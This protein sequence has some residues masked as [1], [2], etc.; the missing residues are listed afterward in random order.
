[1][2]DSNA[3]L[4]QALR[5][6][7]T[8]RPPV[9]MMRQ[10]GRYLPEYMELRR[11]NDFLTRCYNPEIAAEITLQ[12]LRRFSFD[13]GIIFSDIL[14][15]LHKMG[16]DL[17]FRP[18]KGPQIDNPVRNR[19]DV[20]KL[21]E[22]VTTRDLPAVLEAIQI[23]NEKANVPILG[24]AGAPFTMACYL[25]EGGGSRD[26][27]ETK[28][29]MYRDPE[30]FRDLLNRLADAVG[31]HMQAQLDAGAVGVQLFDTWAGA[32]S[33][34]D[35]I[36]FAIPAARRAF[37]H[38]QG[39][40]LYFT[41]DTGPFV[42]HLKEVGSSGIAIDWRID[43]GYARQVLGDIPLQGNLDPIALQGPEEMIRRKVRQIIEKAGPKG[44]IFNLGHGCVPSTSIDGIHVVLDEVAKWKWTE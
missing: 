9:W 32:L 21:K 39:H 18:G 28:R 33:T 30:G 25:I 44:H 42:H 43:M 35:F 6:Q 11:Q 34:E 31:Q 29:F 41:K 2:H 23:C 16:A 12:P 40:T 10:A 22:F 13:A 8:H 37:S 36:E 14:L 7:K 4:L 27:I 19:E 26:W 20:K 15:P 17:H 24:F 3:L 1:M 38:V 5:N